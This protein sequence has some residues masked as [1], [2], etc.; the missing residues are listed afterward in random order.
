MKRLIIVGFVLVG[1]ALF[2]GCSEYKLSDTFDQ[3]EMESAAEQI[4]AYV[5]AEDYEALYALFSEDLQESLSVEYLEAELKPIM[6]QH[7]GF[8]RIR[9][10]A[11]ASAYD[12]ETEQDLGVIM[13]ACEYGRK[14]VRFNIS[15]NT[16]MEL[17][18]LYVK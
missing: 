6:D 16:E 11:V 17:V 9:K 14:K 7:S 1:L 2:G 8:T 10:S 4:I 12:E 3:E 18:G 5:N 13:V 15:F